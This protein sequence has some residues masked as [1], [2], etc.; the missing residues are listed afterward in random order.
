MAIISEFG[1]PP[2]SLAI[3]RD[4]GT[5]LI[6]L[7]WASGTGAQLY[8]A[9]AVDAPAGSWTA[10]SGATDGSYSFNAGATGGTQK[11]YTLRQ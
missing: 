7:T 6:T 5:G 9:T 2:P 1:A 11:F 8:E 3:S 10:V 4:A